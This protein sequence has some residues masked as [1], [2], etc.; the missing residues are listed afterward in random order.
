MK[1]DE[2]IQKAGANARAAG[3]SVFDNPYGRTAA[4]PAATG[5]SLAEWQLKYE[6]WRLGW[7]MENAMRQS[8]ADSRNKEG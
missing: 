3:G 8:A 2:A 5:E 7:E 6:A 1:L 4:M